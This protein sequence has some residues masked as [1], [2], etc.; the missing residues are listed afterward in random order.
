MKKSSASSE[1]R[2]SMAQSPSYNGLLRGK[3]ALLEE[4]GSPKALFPE[5]KIQFLYSIF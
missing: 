3:D 4:F 5:E 2:K 1:D